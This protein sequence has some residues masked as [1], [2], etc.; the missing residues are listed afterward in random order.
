M[1]V[2]LCVI[3]RIIESAQKT[4]NRIVDIF[5]KTFFLLFWPELSLTKKNCLPCVLKKISIMNSLR[6]PLFSEIKLD[7]AQPWPTMAQP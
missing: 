5:F 6:R 2:T 1:N 3:E 7:S 4:T